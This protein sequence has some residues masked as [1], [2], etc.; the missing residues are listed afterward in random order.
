[1]Q[2]LNPEDQLPLTQVVFHTLLS[3]IDGRRHGYAIAQEVETRTGGR[4][5]MGPGTL[6]GCLHRLHGLGYI[7]E[8]DAPAEAADAERRRYYRLCDL[9][10]TVLEAE[11]HRLED[12]V[13]LLRAKKVL[14]EDGAP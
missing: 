13:H 7:D 9:G 5:K 3:L 12:E 11:A 8:C 2:E 4:V 1:M 10:R 14:G 6:Y